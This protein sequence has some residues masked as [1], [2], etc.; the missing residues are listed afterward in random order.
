MVNS[1]ERVEER[2]APEADQRQPVAPD[3]LLEQDRHEIVHEAPAQRGHEE[4]DQ[5]VNE[6]PSHGPG[7]GSRDEVLGHEVPHRVGQEGPDE[8]GE[9]I[10]EADVER[11]LHLGDGGD[12]VDRHQQQAELGDRVD[13]DR[14]FAPL[15]CLGLTKDQTH[16]R[17]AY[18]Q[19]PGPEDR[20]GQAD[21]QDGDRGVIYLP[22]RQP[23]YDP[24]KPAQE[25]V[26]DEPVG[27]GVG[28]DHPPAARREELDSGERIQSQELEG[29]E[30]SAQHRS[31]HENQGGHEM[32]VDQALVHQVLVARQF[33]FQGC[34]LTLVRI[35]K[36]IKKDIN[37]GARPGAASAPGLVQATVS[38][39]R[40]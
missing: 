34:F 27:D 17:G 24:L 19:L 33:L 13:P 23:G 18:D 35:D 3:R 5:V 38:A 14:R 26:G 12:V 36:S 8:G 37:T 21:I 10:P 20:P 30:Q 29:H 7:G 39:T 40:R 15:H 25:R 31:A 22:K 16:G 4:P 9:K 2:K 28:V 1:L 32:P 6:Q 11:P